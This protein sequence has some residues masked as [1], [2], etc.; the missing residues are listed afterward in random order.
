M[1]SVEG[2]RVIVERVLE[3][4]TRIPYA[5]GDLRTE[6]VFDR[7]RDRYLLVTLG[8]DE[9]RRVHYP[10]V[11]V[12]RVGEKWWIERDA[13]EHGIGRELVEAGIPADRIV[14]GYRPPEVRPHSGFATA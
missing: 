7:A 14:L 1:D 2:E 5:H 12:D 11:Q 13:T 4:Y 10:L 9:G 8:W 3:E 6:A